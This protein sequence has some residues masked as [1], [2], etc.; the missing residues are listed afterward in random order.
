MIWKTEKQTSEV[1]WNGSRRKASKESID[2]GETNRIALYKVEKSIFY[3]KYQE[4][5]VRF[6]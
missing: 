6:N 5:L 4:K 1:D 3:L 2:M